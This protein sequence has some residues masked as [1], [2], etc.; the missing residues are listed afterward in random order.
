MPFR[1]MARL[2]FRIPGLN[3]AQILERVQL[4]LL[5][6]DGED[7]PLYRELMERHH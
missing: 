2:S 1:G 7:R 3:E 6:P 5:D 4:R